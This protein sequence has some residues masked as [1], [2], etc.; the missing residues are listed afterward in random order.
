MGKIYFRTVAYNAE[1][2]IRRCI[3]SVLNQTYRSEDIEYY[4]CDNG[5]TDKTGEIIDSYVQQ[6][7]RVRKF[8]NEKNHVWDSE[9]VK[10]F[11]NLDL[12]MR[13]GDYLCFLDADDAYHLDFLEKMI[14]FI[15]ANNL[16]IGVCGNNFINAEK[17]CIAGQRSLNVD[18]IIKSSNDFSD[19]F[20]YYHAL[21]R[22]AWGKIY[23]AGAA[24]SLEL[25]DHCSEERYRLKEKLLYGSDTFN[26]FAALRYAS[27]VGIIHNVL[28]DYFLSPKSSSYIYY[29]GR[30]DS[31]IILY[32][33]ALDFLK[34]KCGYVSETNQ[35]FI[36]LVYCNA[37][38]DTA[39]NILNSNLS[40]GEKAAELCKILSHQ[41]TK[42]ALVIQNRTA[43]DN[44]N[45]LIKA[46]LA[47]GS[48]AEDDIPELNEIMSYYCPHC[49]RIITKANCSLFTTDNILLNILLS[50]D[51]PS[52]IKTLTEYISKNKFVKQYDLVDMLKT[53]YNDDA[54]IQTICE[55][56]FIQKHMDIFMLVS[57]KKY[58]DALEIMT[59]YL[60][61]NNK[62]SEI[63]IQLYLSLAA[64]LECADEFIFGKIKLAML[65]VNEKRLDECRAVLEELS[66]MGVED[67]EDITEIKRKLNS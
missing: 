1:K 21:M 7:K 43:V 9:S 13:E 20:T 53:L 62:T 14:P 25:S 41:I 40:V 46:L 31:D 48:K 52:M 11:L 28:H 39:Q 61:K 42:N 51:K 35:L 63:F 30:I 29:P 19:M 12:N 49:G 45:F 26:V 60:L 59:D 27:R 34:T 3:D 15:E 47:V 8:R 50:D 65:Y 5:S 36:Y 4:I 58:P 67:N 44:K 10:A 54:L 64:G 56:K 22:T 38:K 24:K 37:V 6:D 18:I 17:G 55:G 32:E 66:E 2:T 57:E 23:T 33:D 16:D